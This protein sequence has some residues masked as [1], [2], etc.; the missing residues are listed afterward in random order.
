MRHLHRSPETRADGLHPAMHWSTVRVDDRAEVC[1]VL[2]RGAPVVFLPGWGSTPWI[3][4]HALARLARTFRVYAPAVPGFAT[5]PGRPPD[6]QTLADCSTWLGRFLDATGLGP[7][8][9]VGHS[10]GGALAIR[11]AHDLPDRVARLVLVNSVGG[12][13]WPDVRG[14]VPPLGDGPPWERGAA[15]PR[16][17][18]P[19]RTLAS[20]TPPRPTAIARTDGGDREA[21]GYADPIARSRDLTAELSRLAQRRLPASLVWSRGDRLIPRASVESLRRLLGRPPVFTVPGGHGWLITDPEYFGNAMRT[22]LDGFPIGV[23]P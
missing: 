12:D 19:P 11:A 22:V 4:R 7:V 21:V 1:A 8:T 17:A 9:L 3:Y 23:A 6:N 13:V 14:A 16:E 15:T 20:P 18:L 10:F 5:A 2:G